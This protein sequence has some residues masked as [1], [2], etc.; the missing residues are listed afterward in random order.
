MRIVLFLNNWGA[1]K[2]AAWL[3]HRAEVIVGAV[4][5]HADD[6]RFGPQIVSALDLPADRLWT[7]D[8]LRSPEVILDLP[9]GKRAWGKHS[10][11]S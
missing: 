9:A 7:S 8:Q 4:L 11:I 3:R 5:A 2:V 1:W 6:R 10:V